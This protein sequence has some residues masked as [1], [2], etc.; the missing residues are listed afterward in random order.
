LPQDEKELPL[1]ALALGST[2]LV[3]MHSEV[4]VGTT[5]EL[6]RQ[7][8]ELDLWTMGLANA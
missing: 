6:G 2:A 7:R 1:A 8:P 4:M 5:L 3:F